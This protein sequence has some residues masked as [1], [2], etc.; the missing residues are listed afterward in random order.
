MTK[1]GGVGMGRGKTSCTVGGSINKHSHLL[2][3]LEI[4]QNLGL[5]LPYGPTII[6][7]RH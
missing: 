4:S 7:A 2:S 6:T 1:N 3:R 5:E